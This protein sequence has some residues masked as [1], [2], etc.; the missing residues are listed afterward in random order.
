MYK[1]KH[2][3]DEQGLIRMYKA[4]IQPYFIYAIE[5]WGHSVKSD[6]DTLV[7]L[8][9]KVLRIVFNCKRSD[10][11]WRHNKGCIDTITTLYEKVIKKQCYKHHM[12]LLPTPFSDNIMPEFN[13]SQ[14]QYKLTRTSLNN[15]YDYKQ[16]LKDSI[17]KTN[18]STIWN[19]QPLEFKSIPYCTDKINAHKSIISILS[20]QQQLI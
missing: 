13:L 4:F 16:P 18:C 2:V 14:L 15:M 6:T 12:G 9:S 1:C 11:A 17:F 5:V 20:C 10:D 3:M 19:S 8:Q 7:R